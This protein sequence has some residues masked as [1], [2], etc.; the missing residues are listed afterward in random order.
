MRRT[1]RWVVLISTA[2]VATLAGGPA[3]AATYRWELSASY[4]YADLGWVL[5]GHVAGRPCELRASIWIQQ[6]DFINTFHFGAQLQSNRVWTTIPVEDSLTGTTTDQTLDI[7]IKGLDPLEKTTT[8][9]AIVGP[10][11]VRYHWRDIVLARPGT[12]SGKV[13]WLGLRN[14]RLQVTYN[15]L[16]RADTYLR[17]RN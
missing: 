7:R 16:T 11:G 2:L 12:W 9:Y 1:I 5:P 6:Q 10:D 13:A 17:A 8:S 3:Q 15:Q 4:Q 14:P